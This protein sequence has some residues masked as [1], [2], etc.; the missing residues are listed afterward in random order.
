M[1]KEREGA[2]YAPMNHQSNALLSV[3]AEQEADLEENKVSFL[4]QKLIKTPVALQ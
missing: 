3:V 1:V 2:E 4:G